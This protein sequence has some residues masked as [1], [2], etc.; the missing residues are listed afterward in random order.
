MLAGPS[1]QRLEGGYI[2]DSAT[3]ATKVTC[4]NHSLKLQRYRYYTN[5]SIN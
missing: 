3:L 4:D 1:L 5:G 2:S